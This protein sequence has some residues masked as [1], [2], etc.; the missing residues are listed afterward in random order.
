MLKRIIITSFITGLLIILTAL[1]SPYYNSLMK[2]GQKNT[3]KTA[4][5]AVKPAVA[6]VTPKKIEKEKVRFYAKVDE[7]NFFI[8]KDN[9]WTKTFIKGVNIRSVKP[10]YNAAAGT[11]DKSDYARWLIDIGKMN[12]N[13]VEVDSLQKPEFYQALYDYNIKAK[14]PI[15]LFQGISVN[16][17]D[18]KKYGNAYNQ[19]FINDFKTDIKNQIDALHGKA[20]LK[21]QAD[22]GGKYSCDISRYVAGLILGG[23][24]DLQFIV[25][26][27]QKKV[28]GGFNGKYLYTENSTPFEAFLCKM[29][30]YALS[31]ETDDYYSQCPISFANGIKKDP[32]DASDSGVSINAEHIKAQSDLS[33][34]IFAS[35]NAIDFDP[36]S[37]T[38]GSYADAFKSFVGNAVKQTK[39]P[40]ILQFGIPSFRGTDSAYLKTASD[41]GYID[42]NT[43]SRMVCDMIKNIFDGGCAGGLISD[44]QDDW[45]QKSVGTEVFKLTDISDWSDPQTENQGYGLM[46]FDPG[47]NKSISYLDADIKDMQDFK[48][49]AG[50][51]DIKLYMQNDEKYIYIMLEAKNI[52]FDKDKIIIP[53][54][55]DENL[56]SDHMENLGLNFNKNADFV[57]LLNGKSDSHLLV[58]AY[59]DMFYYE[60]GFKGGL[61]PRQTKYESPNGVFNPINMRLSGKSK[62]LSY[63]ETGKLI[64]GDANP[65][66]VSY[67]S[68]AD[69]YYDKNILEIRI[70]YALLN[71]I[72]PPRGIVAA[73]LYK[74][75]GKTLKIDGMNIGV[76]LIDKNNSNENINMCHYKL[77][78]WTYPTYHERLKPAY[79]SVQK[80]FLSV[81]N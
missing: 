18:I 78:T 5:A 7:K 2:S 61:L 63:Y 66:N 72:D 43:Q 71:F 31:Q 51:G 4:V 69:F 44:W 21:T 57:I 22:T 27:N 35:Y 79:Y 29:G 23:E 45:S 47:D 62:T 60:N 54:G 13:A 33:A 70:P 76:S 8:L 67:D 1:G 25:D 9:V 56:G 24:W 38:A 26:T 11:A 58:N 19:N 36:D 20:S 77:K 17:S 16:D 37:N 41:K 50:S 75:T 28:S 49:V 68:S 55:T 81:G 40:V 14:N 53:I 65:E 39:M 64:Y 48:P 6:T 3:P 15:M 46:A 52:D 59:Y 74:E 73:D 42:E 34:G 30:D 80:A 32:Y 10:G 12:A